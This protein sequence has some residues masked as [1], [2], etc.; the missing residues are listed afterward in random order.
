MCTTTPSSVRI[1]EAYVACAECVLTHD[2]VCAPPFQPGWGLKKS[3]LVGSG[4]G[5][6]LSAP[7]SFEAAFRGAGQH[8]GQKQQEGVQVRKWKEGLQGEDMV[9]CWSPLGGLWDSNTIG[10]QEGLVEPGENWSYRGCSVLI[11]VV[12]PR[13]PTVT[14]TAISV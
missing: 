8:V 6:L 13:E 1:S 7:G 12:R 10:V 11:G 4:N 9:G 2:S 3:M 5:R 14:D